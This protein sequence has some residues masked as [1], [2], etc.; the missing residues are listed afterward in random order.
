[1]FNALDDLAG[2]FR[3]ETVLAVSH[4]GAMIATLGSIAPGACGLPKHGND[5][6][7]GTAYAVEHSSDGWRFL[8]RW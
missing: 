1:M 8:S 3:G 5:I 7:G 6:P 4:G 2:R